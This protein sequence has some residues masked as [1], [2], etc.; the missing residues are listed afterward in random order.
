[1]ISTEY[2][3][4]VPFELADRNIVSTIVKIEVEACKETLSGGPHST[5]S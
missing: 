5:I 1:L 4:S 3:T 2:V